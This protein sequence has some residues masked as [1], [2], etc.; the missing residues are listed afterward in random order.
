KQAVAQVRVGENTPLLN[1]A[2]DVGF[3]LW[4]STYA[5]KQAGGPWALLSRN[6]ITVLVD[7]MKTK[8]YGR[9]ITRL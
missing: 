5:V 4:R 6:R 9:D 8:V 3:F 7:W 1:A 2:G